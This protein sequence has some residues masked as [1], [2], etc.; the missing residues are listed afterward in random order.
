ME[1]TSDRSHH[2]LVYT[3]NSQ[4]LM[5]QQLLQG[6][7]RQDSGDDGA[8][9]YP[10]DPIDAYPPIPPEYKMGTEILGEG[11]Y[12][13]VIACVNKDFCWIVSKSKSKYDGADKH[14]ITEAKL[15]GKI[16][17]PNILEIIVAGSDS[18]R[19]VMI[20]P[21]MECDLS[22]RSKQMAQDGT[23]TNSGVIKWG[24]H[25]LGGLKFLHGTHY[26]VHR[27]IKPCNLLI[28][29]HDHHVK[30]ADLGLSEHGYCCTSN[31]GTPG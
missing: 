20:A 9:P 23:L 5:P 2:T 24:M 10:P 17:H 16:K 26:I 19:F 15:M 30:I 12:K 3:P 28:T 25:I 14:L 1:P 4:V 27:D 31:V 8:G 7:Q 29:G 13:T 22:V 11:G 6:S 18:G 21:R